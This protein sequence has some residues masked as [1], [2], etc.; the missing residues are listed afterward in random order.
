MTATGLRCYQTRIVPEH[1]DQGRITSLLAITRDASKQKLVEIALRE[2]EERF[3]NAFKYSLIGMALVSLDGN[4]LKVNPRICSILGYSEDELFGLTFQ[5]L[6]HP[7]DLAND[8]NYVRQILAGE[9]ETYTLEKRYIHKQGNIIWAL[10]AVALVRDGA[11]VPLYFIAQ[12]EDISKR[13]RAEE[14]LRLLN[15]DL[16]QRV[17]DR[18]G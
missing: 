5:E 6:T 18:R 13:R 14:Q 9:I 15:A 1:D 4:W 16:E 8:L 3:Q 17:A 10:L 11:G 2:S 12:L 7:D